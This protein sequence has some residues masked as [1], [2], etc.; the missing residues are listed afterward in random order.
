MC[1]KWLS[2]MGV[3]CQLKLCVSENWFQLLEP[4][5]LWVSWPVVAVT[6]ASGVSAPGVSGGLQ[7]PA[8]GAEVV[9][10]SPNHLLREGVRE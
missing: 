8:P 4:G 9:C 2:A 3:Q 6:G 1:F 7:P 5:Q 10:V